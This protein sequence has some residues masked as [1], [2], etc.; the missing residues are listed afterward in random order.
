MQQVKQAAPQQILLP[1]DVRRRLRQA[2]PKANATSAAAK[3]MVEVDAGVKVLARGDRLLGSVMEELQQAGCVQVCSL[4]PHLSPRPA[5]GIIV[6]HSSVCARTLGT[7]L[8][9]YSNHCS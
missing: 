4:I 1:E 2:G 6:I 8:N 3:G 5:A 9:M 7:L